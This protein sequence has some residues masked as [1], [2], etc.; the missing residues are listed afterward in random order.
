MS[1]TKSIDIEGTTYQV[2]KQLGQGGQGAVSLVES[3]GQRYAAKK[4]LLHDENESGKKGKENQGRNNRFR[5]EVEYCKKFHSRNV[6]KIIAVEEE[7]I[8]TGKQKGR[9][10]LQ[11][12]M[13]YFGSTLRDWIRE[14]VSLEQRFDL[15]SQLYDAVSVIHGDGV[16]HRDIKPEN[17]LVDSNGSQ[18]VLAD[19]GIARI[20]D[21]VETMTMELL[22]NRA[23]FAPEQMKGKDQKEVGPAADIFALGLITNELFT[24]SIPRGSIFRRI[25]DV[26]PLLSELDALVERMTDRDPSKRNLIASA[27]SELKRIACIHSSSLEDVENCLRT[28]CAKG[29]ESQLAKV[30][31]DTLNREIAEGVLNPVGQQEMNDHAASNLISNE[32]SQTLASDENTKWAF[33]Q[34]HRLV[35][36]GCEEY[37]CEKVLHS[38]SEEA[39]RSIEDEIYRQAAEEVLLASRLLQTLSVEEWGSYN[40]DYHRNIRFS[41]NE[42]LLHAAQSVCF[43]EACRSK[44]NYEATVYHS[45]SG[46]KRQSTYDE[47]PSEEQKMQLDAWL[48]KRPFSLKQIATD[49][50]IHGKIRKY[51][52]SCGG[53]HCTELLKTMETIDPPWGLF[54]S[55]ASAICLAYGIAVHLMAIVNPHEDP[56]IRM[57]EFDLWEFVELSDVTDW[58]IEVFLE[59]N[60]QA[61][62]LRFGPSLDADGAK[63]ILE[64]L[65]TQYLG[66]NFEIRDSKA[67]V[68]FADSEQYDRF[69]HTAREKAKGHYIFEGDVIGVL[70]PAF[71]G[72]GL[73]QHIWSL[74]FDVKHTL[75]IVLGLR[76]I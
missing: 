42:N 59:E 36:G 9:R 62:D 60:K 54:S 65:V 19:F 29:W 33:Y 28:K 70:V 50:K 2:I 34:L 11:Y 22:A 47:G 75:A 17:I 35:E 67:V 53:Y 4:I 71:S 66:V 26:H 27:E 51:F 14:S 64:N 5:E 1:M 30:K 21:S 25:S 41:P 12:V 73:I 56:R 38:P 69:C 37:S 74:G 23:Y 18:L 13:P 15:L 44:F 43:L 8:T 61:R 45:V 46:P 6:I 48:S 49:E 76:E 32:G 52:I 3:D 58:P 10:Q 7:V 24:L 57:D 68:N 31:R 72:G 63:K 20:D 39:L 40:P 16:V 55:A